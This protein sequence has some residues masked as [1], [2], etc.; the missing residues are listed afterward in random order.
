MDDNYEIAFGLILHAGNSKS[1]SM[2]AIE[3]A[4]EYDMQNARR[5]LK[6]AGAELREAHQVQTQLITAEANGDKTEMNIIMTHAQDHLMMAII[7]KDQAEEFIH[8][9]EIIRKLSKDN[10]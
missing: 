6:E 5:L 7:M 1:E 3:A 10:S 9:Y 8:L 2:K 4:R